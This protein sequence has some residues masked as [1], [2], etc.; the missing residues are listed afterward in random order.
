MTSRD[1][2]T[3]RLEVPEHQQVHT[4][5]V[6][7]V[8]FPPGSEQALLSGSVDGLVCAIDV[9]EPPPLRAGVASKC[10]VLM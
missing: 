10:C 6:S 1:H 7:Q 4:D 3:S 5:A 2:V 9:S 8:R